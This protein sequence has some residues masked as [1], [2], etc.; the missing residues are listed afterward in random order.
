MTSPLIFPNLDPVAF[1]IGPIAVRWYA[2]AYIV[3]FV[4]ALPLVKKLCQKEPVVASPVLM[5]DFLFYAVLGV[6]LGGR[7]G[8][9]CFYRPLH[10]L[11]H[12][13]EV[14]ETWKGGMSFHGGA[15][16]VI[17]AMAL[18]CQFR[19]ISFLAFADRIVT[20]VPIGLALGRCANFINGELWG[21]VTTSHVPWV[22]IFP[23]A[24]SL[25]RHPSELYEALTEGVLLFAVMMLAFSRKSLRSHP[26]FLS[27]LFLCGY[28]CARAFCEF[29]REPD[30]NIGFLPGGMTM[31]QLLCLPMIIAGVLLMVYGLKRPALPSSAS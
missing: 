5:D 26:G 31:G 23:Q 15:I 20:V 1:Q 25:P 17:I 19:K 10:Y 21:R 2:L 6:L 12:P 9:V 3:A 22:M 7:L 30:A 4:L 28:G 24:G 8:Y 18:F 11:H 16:G 27:G 29:F 13:L 14:F